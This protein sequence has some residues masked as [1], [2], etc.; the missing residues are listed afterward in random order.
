M[1]IA[2][3]CA[4]W[5]LQGFAQHSVTIKGKVK[6]IEKDFKVS[7]YQ[8]SG[9]DKKILAEV[10]VNDDHTYSITV[11][12]DKPGTA[13]VDCGHGKVLTFGWKMKIWILIFVV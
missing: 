11:P 4:G 3:L 8:R 7:V 13:T 12:F 1:M 6:F 2:A 5:A 10:P 9:T